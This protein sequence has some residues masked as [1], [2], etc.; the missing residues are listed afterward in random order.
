MAAL[1][2]TG[3]LALAACGGNE[4]GGSAGGG[5][6]QGLEVGLALDTGGPGD[7][8]VN[9]SAVAGVAAAVEEHDG[10]FRDLSPNAEGSNRADLLV[11]LADEGYDPVIAVGRSYG[12][13]VGDVA[14]RYP[15]T[16]FAVIDVSVQEVGADNV[17]GL[18]FAEEEGS[19]LA[20]AAAALKTERGHI[21]FVGGAEIPDLEK[22]EAGYLAGA[23]EVKPDIRIDRQYLP[24]AGGSGGPAE[25][26][27]AAQVM[28][29]AGADIVYQA[30]D[31]SGM[32]V[33]Q[34]AAA[35]GKRAIGVGSDQYRTVEDPA[36]QAV[37]MTSMV[38]RVDHAV[39]AFVGDFVEG[40]VAGGE[41]VVNDLATEGVGL[42]TSGGFIDDIQADIDGYRRKIVDGEIEVPVTV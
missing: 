21:G 26:Q 17:T 1:L 30:A 7:R 20:G 34:A 5:G 22:F 42:A 31:A 10:K 24:P 9:D 3:T 8:P 13:V 33:F 27:L 16:T 29:D 35:S 12:N 25:G 39:Q 40:D 15:G 19:F 18:L 32:G 41:D 38:K 4:H 36:L 28:Y 2:L 37:I 11:Q 6:D 23:R 14:E